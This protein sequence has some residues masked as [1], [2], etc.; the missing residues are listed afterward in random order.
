MNLSG[1]GYTQFDILFVFGKWQKA[2]IKSIFQ[3]S[4]SDVWLNNPTE[5][6]SLRHNYIWLPI[7]VY[8]IYAALGNSVFSFE[9]KN[10]KFRHKFDTNMTFA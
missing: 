10:C 8:M 3:Y 5:R 2:D 6:Y 1:Q 4:K 9:I 7:P